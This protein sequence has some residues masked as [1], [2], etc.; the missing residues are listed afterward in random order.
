MLQQLLLSIDTRTVNLRIVTHYTYC[1]KNLQ[2]KCFHYLCLQRQL[3]TNLYPSLIH[4]AIIF[5]EAFAL[6]CIHISAI[7][8]KSPKIVECDE[9]MKIKMISKRSSNHYIFLLSV[10]ECLIKEGICFQKIILIYA[11]A[12]HQK[13]IN[14]PLS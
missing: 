1:S 3:N 8:S 5:G 4:Y 14:T 2:N 6:I 11:V 9:S 13:I 7:L 10:S 12:T